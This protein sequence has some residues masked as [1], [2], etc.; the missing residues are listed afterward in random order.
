[1][2]LDIVKNRLST[3]E[4]KTIKVKVSVVFATYQTKLLN[5][6]LTGLILIKLATGPVLITSNGHAH[7]SKDWG[8]EDVQEE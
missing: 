5:H 6:K 8:V 7:G 3:Q 1:M 2:Q 4:T